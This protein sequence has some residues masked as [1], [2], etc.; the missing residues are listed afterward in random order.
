MA[1]EPGRPKKGMSLYA[2]LLAQPTDS[3]AIIS[4]APVVFKQS[5]E[6]EPQPGDTGKKPLLKDRMY[7]FSITLILTHSS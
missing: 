3:P 6:T 5:S 7:I 1:S 2:D 4:R